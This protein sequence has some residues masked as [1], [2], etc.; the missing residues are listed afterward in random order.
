MPRA[1]EPP[2]GGVLLT[3]L[4]THDFLRTAVRDVL[5]EGRQPLP[6]PR[7]VIPS[8]LTCHRAA[9]T[10]HL[11][12][13]VPQ[14][15]WHHSRRKKRIGRIP[16]AHLK[17]PPGGPLVSHSGGWHWDRGAGTG[18]D[19]PRLRGSCSVG[20]LLLTLYVILYHNTVRAL[21]QPRSPP[22]LS[23]TAKQELAR[24]TPETPHSWAGAAILFRSH[25]SW[26]AR[27]LLCYNMKT[28]GQKQTQQ[29]KTQHVQFQYM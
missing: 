24:D 12:S 19:V 18:T 23:A 13:D 2:P 7:Q 17:G 14:G 27:N 8:Q 28:C 10:S 15:C 29:K 9:G 22:L 26:L 1:T 21:G 11:K 25:S 16:L 6:Q 20:P 4:L 3:Y 5:G